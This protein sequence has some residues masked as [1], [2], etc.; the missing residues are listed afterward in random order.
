MIIQKIE[1][2]PVTFHLTESYATAYETISEVHNVVCR[3]ETQTGLVGWGNAAPDLHVTGE[4]SASVLQTIQDHLAPVLRGEDATRLHYLNAKLSETLPGNYAAKASL[5]IALYD[6]LGK[7]AGLPLY[8]LLGYYRRKIL[9]SVTIGIT[10]P[11][12]TVRRAVALVKRGFQALKLKGGRDWEEDVERVRKVR[13]VVGEEIYLRLDANQGYDVGEALKLIQALEGVGI[14]FLEQPTRAEQLYSLQEVTARSKIPI[15][16]D[17]TV[18]TSKDT[19]QVAAHSYADHINIKLMKAGGL[20]NALRINIVAEAGEI[21]TMVGCMDES[22]I[23][24]AAAAHFAVAFKNV[25]YADLDGHLD[26]DRDVAR[27]GI[28]IEDGFVIPVD[29]PGLGI[30]VDL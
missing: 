12:E 13:E 27:G 18:L 14:E 15:M 2:F 8:Q 26:L 3:I 19:F 9:T 6:L 30:E 23:S 17:E 5:N 16:A 1:V 29:A 28:T 11:E 25:H 7:R 22:V 24:I 20:T 21:E 4:T 10:P